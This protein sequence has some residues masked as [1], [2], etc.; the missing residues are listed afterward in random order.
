MNQK[1]LNNKG[2]IPHQSSEEKQAMEQ[3]ALSTTVTKCRRKS[4]L[5]GGMAPLL[6][7]LQTVR[8]HQAALLNGTGRKKIK[9]PCQGKS[10]ET[11]SRGGKY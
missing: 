10:R 7:R 4:A 3:W 6:V 11:M 2:K 5:L 1:Q 9:L 8:T